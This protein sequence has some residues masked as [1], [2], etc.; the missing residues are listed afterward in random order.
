[1]IIKLQIKIR[2]T[3]DERTRLRLPENSN[4]TGNTTRKKLPAYKAFLPGQNQF[5]LLKRDKH[6][7]AEEYTIEN[8]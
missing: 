2:Q 5:F 6:Q 7:L 8:N 1:M 3:T 4:I